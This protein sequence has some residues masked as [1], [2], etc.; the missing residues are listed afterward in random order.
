MIRHHALASDNLSTA[1]LWGR[2]VAADRVR[3]TDVPRMN[4][5]N[6]AQEREAKVG[7]LAGAEAVT[8]EPCR[9]YGESVQGTTPIGKSCEHSSGP[10]A[11]FAGGVVGW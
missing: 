9:G 3:G 2:P 8:Q 10:E 1:W 11:H 7:A 4:R 6:R 5:S